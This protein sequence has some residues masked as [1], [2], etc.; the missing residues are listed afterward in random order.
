MSK[1]GH[2]P[3]REKRSSA[4]KSVGSQFCS[5]VSKNKDAIFNI[6]N[7]V[8][9]E[10]S[11]HVKFVMLWPSSKPDVRV[12]YQKENIALL[13]NIALK[14]WQFI[15]NAVPK[16]LGVEVIYSESFNLWRK[17]KYVHIFFSGE[18]NKSLNFTNLDSPSELTAIEAVDIP[19]LLAAMI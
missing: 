13:K 14:N 6:D 18:P 12:P 17:L 7:M 3:A 2:S 16:A 4:R 8:S 1:T 5:R 19:I 9:L 10:H 11:T 15:A